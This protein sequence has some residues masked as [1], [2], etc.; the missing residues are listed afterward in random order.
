MENSWQLLLLF[1]LAYYLLI[2]PYVLPEEMIFES[3]H[4]CIYSE[5]TCGFPL[6]VARPLLQILGESISIFSIRILVLLGFYFINK[7]LSSTLCIKLGKDTGI[8]Y[9]V[10][11]SLQFY[12]NMNS[13]RLNKSNYEILLGTLFTDFYIKQSYYKAILALTSFLMLNL[14][15]YELSSVSDF[16]VF[17][18]IH[19]FIV[20]AG[21][22]SFSKK[23]KLDLRLL[24]LKIIYPL[25]LTLLPVVFRSGFMVPFLTMVSA[26]GLSKM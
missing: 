16:Y 9:F 17:E 1:I 8:C 2:I 6:S 5:S 26:W 25:I 7:E 21:F 14:W 3:T 23:I 11:I 13:S 4:K 19:F 22:F 24:E 18:E 12:P 10:L 15:S 20:L